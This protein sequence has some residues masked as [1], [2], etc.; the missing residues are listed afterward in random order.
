LTVPELKQEPIHNDLL[1]RRTLARWENEGGAPAGGHVAPIMKA[2]PSSVV[3]YKKTSLF[4]NATIPHGLLQDHRT[5][6]GVW[7]LI[8]VERGS[9]RYTINDK[10]VHLLTPGYPGVVEPAVTHY[11]T[12]LEDVLF[13]VEF[14]REKEL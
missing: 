2:L 14:Y 1:R 11:I 5:K 3:A 9:L 4:T 10:E 7:G 6:P 13:F 12:P 8:Q